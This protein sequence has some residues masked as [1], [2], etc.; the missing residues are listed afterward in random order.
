MPNRWVRLLPL[1]ALG[2]LLTLSAQAQEGNRKLKSKVDPVY[3][4]VART[5]RIEGAVKLQVLV[6][7]QGSVKDTKILGGNPLLANA[8]IDAV[9]RWKYEAGPEENVLVT[10][11][12][13]H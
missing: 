3:P 13:K 10:I 11:E 5:M 4:E 1:I 8:A 2:F 6:T 7:A 9:K 12:F